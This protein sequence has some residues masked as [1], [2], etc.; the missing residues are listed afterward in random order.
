MNRSLARKLVLG[1]LFAAMAAAFWNEQRRPGFCAVTAPPD[2]AA[3]TPA[4]GPTN[5]L[6]EHAI[7]RGRQIAAQ[8]FSLLSTNL[9]QAIAAGGPA[10][11]LEVCSVKAVG[12]AQAVAATNRVQLARISHRARNP[13]G[14]A[15]AAELDVLIQF[16]ADLTAGR[17]PPP[18][19]VVTNR[20]TVTFYSPIIITDP[21]CLNCHGAPGTDIQPATLATIRRL[22]PQDQAVGFKL[23][24]L[25]GLWRIEFARTNLVATLP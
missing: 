15:A 24:D 14:R 12:L 8:A 2:V 11:A 1:G 20:D 16:Q 6:E 23:G 18:P 5:R 19:I 22:Y 13:N 25:R 7:A 17:V 9:Q 3:L 10:N 21:V 4:A